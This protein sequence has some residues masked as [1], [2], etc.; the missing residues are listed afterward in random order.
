MGLTAAHGRAELLKAVLQGTAYEME[1]IR[2]R[3]EEVTGTAI[4]EVLATGGGTRLAGWL[5]IKADVSGC[6]YLVAQHAE[7]ALLGAALLGGVGAGLYADPEAAL[8]ALATAPE[9]P[10]AAAPGAAFLPDPVRH[11]AHLRLLEGGYV[12]LQEPLRR[13]YASLGSA[14]A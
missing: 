3:A 11:A 9:A 8:R 6:R 14:N 10:A 13:Y 2:R 12:A 1:L 5:Q 7:A 4:D